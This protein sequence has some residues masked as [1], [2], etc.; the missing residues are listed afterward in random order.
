VAGTDF[1]SIATNGSQPDR[2]YTASEIEGTPALQALLADL[3]N[4]EVA[5]TSTDRDQRRIANALVGQ[6]VNFIVA[7]PWFFT[8]QGVGPSTGAAR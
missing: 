1:A 5:L 7:T 2:V 4:R 8:R 6:G 3:A